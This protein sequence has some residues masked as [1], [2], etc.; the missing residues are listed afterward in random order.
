[1]KR[2]QQDVDRQTLISEPKVGSVRT[3]HFALIGSQGIV[4]HLVMRTARRPTDRVVTRPDGNDLRACDV[5]RYWRRSRAAVDLPELHIHDL[6]HASL[7][8]AA[9]TQATLAEVIRRAGH[10]TSRAAMIYQHAAENR[11]RELAARMS[12]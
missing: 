6:R 1:V 7:T 10:S 4:R 3:V 12:S 9:Q 8:L 2:Q 11:D 5:H